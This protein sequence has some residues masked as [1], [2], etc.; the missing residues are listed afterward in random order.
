MKTTTLVQTARLVDGALDYVAATIRH[1][2]WWTDGKL[3]NLVIRNAKGYPVFNPSVNWCI[4]GPILE[5]EGISVNRYDDDCHDVTDE[6]R[7]FA[8][9]DWNAEGAQGF[10][11]GPSPAIAILRCYVAFHFGKEVAVPTELLNES[12]HDH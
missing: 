10:S 12:N 2:E 8:T 3:S 11:E 1:P 4:L 6:R 7:W 5:Q 9:Y